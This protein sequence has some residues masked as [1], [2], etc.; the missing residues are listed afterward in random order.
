MSAASEKGEGAVLYEGV[1]DVGL[2]PAL[3]VGIPVGKDSMS[4]AMRWS[5][6]TEDRESINK[7]VVAPLSLIVTSF[8]H[9]QDVRKT[10]TPALRKD[11]KDTVLVLLEIARTEDH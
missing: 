3:G 8:A 7:E 10:W 6:R 9:V 5:D 11:V 1:R 2:C 4:M